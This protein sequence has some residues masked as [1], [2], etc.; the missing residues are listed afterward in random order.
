MRHILYC[1]ITLMT[2]FE[3]Q[4]NTYEKLVV[5]HVVLQHEHSSSS[6]PPVKCC[7]SRT[8][9]ACLFLHLCVLL[10]YHLQI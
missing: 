2:H 1:S 8:D 6:W 7:L 4:H 3:L 5:Q 9:K 10:L